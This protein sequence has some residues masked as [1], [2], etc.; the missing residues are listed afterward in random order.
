MVQ[1]TCA[2]CGRVG[3][4]SLLASVPDSSRVDGYRRVS[5]CSPAHLADVQRLYAA[6]PW[7]L[8]ETWMARIR[9]TLHGADQ[10]LSRHELACAAGLEPDQV[11]RAFGWYRRRLEHRLREM[12]ALAA[13]ERR[14]R[15]RKSRPAA[16]PTR[17][18]SVR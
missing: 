17:C 10:P 8:E 12:A 6:R 5:V 11:D 15:G 9:L 18:H 13:A 14:H 2:A 1:E 16:H 3:R 4:W 7:S